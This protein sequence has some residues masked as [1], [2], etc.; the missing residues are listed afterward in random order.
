MYHVQTKHR[1]VRWANL[2]QNK[3]TTFSL[4]NKIFELVKN[5]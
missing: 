4:Q 1:F 5:F 2:A 3:V